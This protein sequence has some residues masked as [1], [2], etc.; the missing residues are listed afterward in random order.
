MSLVT[1]DVLETKTTITQWPKGTNWTQLKKLTLAVDMTAEVRERLG[2][3][4]ERLTE[5][6]ALQ[7]NETKL[8]QSSATAVAEQHRIKTL[9]VA[10]NRED[11]LHSRYL[12]KLFAL[13]NEIESTSEK[14]MTVRT[15]LEESKL[16]ISQDDGQGVY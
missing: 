5:Y 6:E 15:K 7:G 14:L 13:E 11:E 2:N 16:R 12:K 8:T 3:R 9:M 10:L 4:I 1:H